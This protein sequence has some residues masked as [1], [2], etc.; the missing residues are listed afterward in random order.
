ML[1]GP[2]RMKN[3]FERAGVDATLS[4]RDNISLIFATFGWVG[5]I[6]V[7]PATWGSFA[8]AGLYLLG[9]TIY[10][11]LAIS[12][13]TAELKAIPAD[14]IFK[15]ALIVAI[16]SLFVAGVRAAARV[17]RIT[18]AKDPRIVVIDEVVGQLITFLFLPVKAGWGFVLVGFLAFRV[19][20]IWKPFPAR[21][22]ES[23]PSGLGVMAD[24]VMAGIYAG[25]LTG[26][27]WR[28]GVNF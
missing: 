12:G 21:Q 24:D 17:V 4:T 2:E 8:A 15:A 26:V 10:G 16:V 5:Y 19:F 18:G 25:I 23:L 13:R 1:A 7:V 11:H 14:F 22:L 27:I 20:D 6:P 28:I 9:Q 3:G